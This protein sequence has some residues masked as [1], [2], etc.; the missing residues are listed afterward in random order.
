MYK[1]VNVEF[2][3]ASFASN[4]FGIKK[5]FSALQKIL[6]SN[7]VDKLIPTDFS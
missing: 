4:G 7:K 3:F 5:N 6:E 1:K 2:N